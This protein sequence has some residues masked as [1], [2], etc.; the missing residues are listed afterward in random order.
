MN[1]YY[2]SKTIRKK[3]PIFKFYR[4]FF[5]GHSKMAYTITMKTSSFQSP[6]S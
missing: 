6:K 5:S 4:A 1:K 2:K 3:H